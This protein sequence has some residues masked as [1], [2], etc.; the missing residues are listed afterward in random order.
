MKQ[1]KRKD[2][3]LIINIVGVPESLFKALKV[4][5]AQEGKTRKTLCIELLTDALKTRKT[6]KEV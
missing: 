1:P 5:A 2:R 6:F 3:G 4:R